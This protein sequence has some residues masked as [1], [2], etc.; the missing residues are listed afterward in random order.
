MPD[1]YCRRYHKQPMTMHSAPR[2][3]GT[4]ERK[5]VR[6]AQEERGRECW[7]S[8]EEEGKPGHCGRYQAAHNHD[9]NEG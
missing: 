8:E 5:R 4:T 3:T 7:R 9:R 2:G 6:Q 1:T